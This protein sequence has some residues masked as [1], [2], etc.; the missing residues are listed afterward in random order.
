V[1]RIEGLRD[2]V[3]SSILERA[4][5]VSRRLTALGVPHTLI[6]GLAV[7]VHGHPR[8]TRD[9]DFLVGV[10][11]F[12]ATSPLLV[13]RDDLVDLVRIGSIDLMSVPPKY[14]VLTSELS[15]EDDEIPV[16]SLRGL[17]LTKLDAFRP[18]DREDVRRLLGRDPSQI[19]AVRDY[20][21]AN[22][23]DLVHR[24]AEVL[25]E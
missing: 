21:A 24:L 15:L 20:L 22:A 6:G 17:V 10:E 23:P 13:Y 2:V 16:I 9:V 3:S 5:D 19:R 18:R 12:A 25:G 7:G 11:A 8:T 4:E 14:P 1:S